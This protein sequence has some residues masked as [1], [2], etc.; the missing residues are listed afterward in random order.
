MIAGCV[1]RASMIS[2]AT[3]SVAPPTT[4]ARIPLAESSGSR[5]GQEYQTAGGER[6]KNDGQRHMQAWT[7]EG[8]PVGMTYQ[9]ADVINPLNS[10]SEMCDA[11]NLVSF[12]AEGGTIKNLWTALRCTL[13]VG[14]ECMC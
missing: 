4:C 14:L 7:D 8:S 5:A 1:F 9:V 13:E 12:T 10:V 11:K 3:E 2:G 6:L